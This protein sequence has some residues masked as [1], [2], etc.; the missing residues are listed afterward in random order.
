MGPFGGPAAVVQADRQHPG[1][2]LAATSNAQLFRSADAGATW[3]VIPFPAELRATLHAFVVDQRTPGVLLAGLTSS[4]REYSGI[5]R[6]A[7]GGRSWKRLSDPNLKEVWSIALWSR[8]SSVIAAGTLEGVFL[9]RDGGANW[10]PLQSPGTPDPKPVVSLAFDPLDADIIYAGTPHW[11]W[12]TTDGGK[13]WTPIHTG[14]I[15]DSDIFSIIVDSRRRD[16]VFA[17]ACGGIY[18]SLDGGNKWTRLREAQ[19]ASERTYQVIQH[20]TKPSVL[21]AGTALGLVRSTDNGATWR[22]LSTQSTRAIAFDPSVSDRLFVAAADGL[23]RSDSL[24]DNLQPANRGFSNRRVTSLAVSENVVFAAA[25]ETTGNF[26]LRRTGED[27]AWEPL[28]SPPADP[29]NVVKIASADGAAVYIVASDSLLPLPVGSQRSNRIPWTSSGSRLV[30]LLLAGPDG[31]TFLVATEDGLYQ[32]T[33]AGGRWQ[34]LSLQSLTLSNVNDVVGASLNP[35]FRIYGM[36]KTDDSVFLAATSRG[37]LRSADAGRT[38]T[39]VAGVLG[40]STVTAICKH[41]KTGRVLYAAQYGVILGSRD[42]GRSWTPVV[43]AEGTTAV[44]GLQVL[45]GNRDRLLVLTE[46]RGI[47][48]I[49]LSPDR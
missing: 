3:D 25:R 24:G 31:R 19:G 17:G 40:R 49:D 1:H 15:D 39:P 38:W 30:D 36:V 23:S 29:F 7:D 47:Y 14:M 33:D 20:P 43:T 2:V 26:I 35:Y 9:S 42:S 46:G 48:S 5:F 18:R 27:E 8:D 22:Q 37:L 4:T 6:S 44:L 13:S 21:L 41:P 11:P 34:L 28:S 12:K 16:T 45:G 32:T 10:T